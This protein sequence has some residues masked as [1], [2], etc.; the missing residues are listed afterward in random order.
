MILRR[1][2]FILLFGAASCVSTYAQIDEADSSESFDPISRGFKDLWIQAK[3]PFSI[4]SQDIPW[5]LGGAMTLGVMVSTDQKI[6][7]M[8]DPPGLMG[9]S[10]RRIS[11]T[12]TKFGAEYGIGFLAGFAGYGFLANDKKA[13]E[14]SYLAAEAF[15]TSGFWTQVLKVLAGR[16]RPGA[17]TGPGGKWTG[18]FGSN[19]KEHFSRYDSF[20]SGHTSTAFSLATV[21][22][23]Q[24]SETPLIPIMSYGLAGLVGVSRVTID[25]HWPS[26]VFAGA[27]LGY[28]CA[29]Q[30]LSHN[31]SEVSRSR[32]RSET[33]WMV[34]PRPDGLSLVAQF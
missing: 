17:R 11:L 14:T 29:Q 34:V 5:V 12:L 25:R 30:V 10:T 31:P 1:S 8:V 23:E 21:F 15:V 33:H 6:Y 4:S 18:P 9:T 22:A 24:Y 20:S 16:E 27:L 19:F 26:D 13:L 2:A 28:L 32:G 7:E 3:S